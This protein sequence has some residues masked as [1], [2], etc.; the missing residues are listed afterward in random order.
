MTTAPA[1]MT[2]DEM[3]GHLQRHLA[4]LAENP[5]NVHAWIMVKALRLQLDIPRHELPDRG[6]AGPYDP[7]TV[8]VDPKLGM[9]Y[10]VGGDQAT[11]ATFRRSVTA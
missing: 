4:V 1:P 9:I 3:R 5:A 11:L 7:K 8:I 2:A 10:R 6:D